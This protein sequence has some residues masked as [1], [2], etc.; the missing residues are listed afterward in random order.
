MPAL[1]DSA[2]PAFL[3]KPFRFSVAPDPGLHPPY[4]SGFLNPKGEDTHPTIYLI[5]DPKKAE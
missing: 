2:S 3:T 1:T 4:L 5:P